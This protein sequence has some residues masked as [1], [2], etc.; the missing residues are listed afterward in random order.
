MYDAPYAYE[1]NQNIDGNVI[2]KFCITVCIIKY[3]SGVGN[4]ASQL[5][6][7]PI[8]PLLNE[9]VECKCDIIECI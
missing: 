7:K 5:Q 2:D 9:I 3:L 8:G 4:P 6:F 1:S